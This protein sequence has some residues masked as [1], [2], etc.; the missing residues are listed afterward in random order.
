MR[1]NVSTVFGSRIAKS[2]LAA[3]ASL[4]LLKNVISNSSFARSARNFARP[5][6]YLV[7]S[8]PPREEKKV[9]APVPRVNWLLGARAPGFSRIG[10]I[11]IRILQ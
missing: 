6:A 7:T 9:E 1:F 2:G 5:S 8:A 4:S 10:S 3:S 11:F